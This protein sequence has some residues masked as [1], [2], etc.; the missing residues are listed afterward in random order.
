MMNKFHYANF[1]VIFLDPESIIV[2]TFEKKENNVTLLGFKVSRTV[3]DSLILLF[4]SK[5][6][7]LNTETMVEDF[8]RFFK[9]IRI[10]F[11]EAT[12]S[13]GNPGYFSIEESFDYD[14]VSDL[15]SNEV[16]ENLAK[17]ISKK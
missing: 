14:F 1:V 17:Q 16:I 6:N 12:V 5:A 10:L 13:S 11:V 2:E 8:C 9:T 4:Q 7:W 15:F 3:S